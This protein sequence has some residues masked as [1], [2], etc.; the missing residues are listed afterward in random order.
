MREGPLT[1]VRASALA[2][3]LACLAAPGPAVGQAGAP[4]GGKVRT[5]V[6]DESRHLAAATV[7]ALNAEIFALD[8]AT[9]A[10]IVVV[11]VDSTSG[12]P[13]GEYA[14]VLQ[15]GLDVF[16]R[17][18]TFGILLVWVPPQRAVEIL[19]GS[20]LLRALPDSAARVRDDVIFPAFRRG[21]F[22]EGMRAGVH[23]LAV[24]L[25]SDGEL[26]SSWERQIEVIS[27][28]P[29]QR[30]GLRVFLL[31]LA[32]V[33][34][35]A[36]GA[37]GGR[38]LL[39]RRP[40]KCPNGHG[41]MRLLSEVEDDQCLDEGER[42]EERIASVDYDVWRCAECA[43]T[44]RIPHRRWFSGWH[45]CRDCKRRT[46]SVAREVIESAT[47]QSEGRE[48]VTETCHNCGKRWTSTVSIAR[49][50][51]SAS[52][53]N[54]YSSGGGSGGFGGGSAGGGGAGGRY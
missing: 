30:R 20:A 5:W 52:G 35:V 21:A 10:G 7:S 3:L 43:A 29:A 47:A 28:R 14:R 45:K 9:G 8:S 22:D 36:A 16:R 13:P 41:E 42:L 4:S 31:A 32:T 40:R 46:V 25:R 51:S 44:L 38:R 24:G 54:S 33:P 19:V 23:A 2:T 15:D 1:R 27:H 53:G 50:G 6:V 34:V 12:Y 11:V 49:V 37:W 48:R 26:R 39:R 18:R 17:G